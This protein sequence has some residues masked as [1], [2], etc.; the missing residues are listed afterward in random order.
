M[1]YVVGLM[2]GTSLDGVDAALVSIDKSGLASKVKLV[3]FISIPF[4]NELKEEI[5]QALMIET[6]NSQQICSLNFRLGEIFAEAVKAV[7]EKA[8]F[9]L[10]KLDTIGSHGQT[11]YHQPSNSEKF[12]PSTLQIGEPAVI[13][14]QTRTTVVSN[15]RTM[16]MAAGGQGAPLV[17]FTEFILYRSEEKSRLLQNI[18]GIGNVTVIPK[19]AS[20]DEIA[21]FDTGPGNMMI[22]TICQ[23]YFDLPYDRGGEIAKRGH[24]HRELLDRCMSIPFVL[25][26]PPKSTGRELFGV[27]FVHQLI[28]EFPNIPMEDFV[29]TLTMFTAKSIAENYKTFIFPKTEIDEVIVGGGGSYNGKLIEML[30]A[31]L[32]DVCPVYTQE[33]FGYSSEAKEAIAFAILANETINRKPSNVPSATG[34]ER[35]VILGNI[36]PVPY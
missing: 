2:S 20:I 9:P 26:P 35:A 1:P 22:D 31:E 5:H 8:G 36:T 3:E 6:S 28:Q 19:Q 23:K 18:G 30:Q 27:S 34:A 24:V 25:E 21:A 32:K 10:E 11:I 17:P 15:F 12:V 14:Y 7:C 4:S 16:D 29:A 33:D 13:A